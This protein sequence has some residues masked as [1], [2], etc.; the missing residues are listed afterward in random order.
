MS[1]ALAG[2][3][4]ATSATWEALSIPGPISVSVQYQ[5]VAQSSPTLCNPMNRSSPG[6]PVHH[7]LPEFTQTHVH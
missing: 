3:F 1:P 5:L 2:G 6:L 4:F 7:Q